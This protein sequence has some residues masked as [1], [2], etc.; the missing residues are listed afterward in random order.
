MLTALSELLR[1]SLDTSS[2]IELPLGREL[3][4]VEA[5]LAILHTRFEERVQFRFEIEPETRAALVPSFVLQ[6]LVENA[7]EHGLRDQP[8]PGLITIAARRDGVNLHLSVADN[9]RGASIAG[10]EEGVGLGNTRTRLR[11]LYGREATLAIRNSAG[12]TV[13]ITLPFHVAT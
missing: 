8:Q 12:C 7:V 10:L 13:E 9:G 3:A 1:F 11:E 4:S 2:D 5:Y 6:P